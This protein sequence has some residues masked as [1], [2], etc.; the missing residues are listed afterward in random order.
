MS[1]KFVTPID[2]GQNELQNAVVQNLSSDPGAPIEGQAWYN[3][4]SH[5]L[6]VRRNGAT[7]VLG[8]LDQITAPA[9]DV[10]LNSHKITS[11]AT[12]S[13][14][15]DA[16]TKAYVDGV[17]TGGISW[18]Q[19]VRAA[20]TG[21]G[22]LASSFENGDAID[23]VTLATGDRI[24]IKNQSDGT[25]NGIYVVAASGAPT[26]ATDADAGSELAGATVIV[27]EGTTNADQGFT[28]TNDGTITLGSTALAFVQITAL[29]QVTA[30]AGLTKT[31]ATLDVVA[32]DGSITV[33]AD[34][35]TVGLVPVGKGGTNATDATTARSNLGAV[36]KYAASVGD[37]ASTSI[38]VTHNLG[39]TDVIV[40]LHRV[41]SPFDV[42]EPDIQI[43][44]V[45]TVT[46]LFA[47]APSTNQYRVVV[48]G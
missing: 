33:A 46:L 45:N 4:T 43:T 38:A 39:T 29:G 27:R 1:R 25:E 16:A 15:T 40:Q 2:L 8:S 32:A 36:G 12:P 26:R 31:G 42:V 28:C 48:T 24:L 20:T 35:I 30:G 47:S 23:G 6:K 13:A 37:G 11:L 10:S 5:V 34:S 19:P 41:A 18:K 9:G 3:T 7:L 44:D 17:A 14:D 22:T 21:R